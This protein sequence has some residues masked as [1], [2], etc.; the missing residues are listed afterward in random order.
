MLPDVGDWLQQMVLCQVGLVQTLHLEHP[1][2]WP[3]CLITSTPVR[4][5]S[6]ISCPTLSFYSS[7]D[8]LNSAIPAKY[9]GVAAACSS[10]ELLQ[11]IQG[12]T[13]AWRKGPQLTGTWIISRWFAA[14]PH[15]HHCTCSTHRHFPHPLLQAQTF[16]C[17]AKHQITWTGSMIWSSAF[18]TKEKCLQ[19]SCL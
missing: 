17:S 18:W 9:Q 19:R 5:P 12:R 14:G 3:G 2:C 6:G 13:R 11:R 15:H 1:N 7:R 10:S 16:Y 4:K 8:V